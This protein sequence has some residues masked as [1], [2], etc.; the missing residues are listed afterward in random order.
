MDNRY[1]IADIIG[2]PN[3]LNKLPYCPNGIITKFIMPIYINIFTKLAILG[4]NLKRAG[5][6]MDND[7]TTIGKVDFTKEKFILSTFTNPKRLIIHI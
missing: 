3:P 7:N 4:G 1:T 5:N 6:D 2:S